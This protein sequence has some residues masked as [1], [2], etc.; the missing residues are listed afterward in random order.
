MSSSEEINNLFDDL[1]VGDNVRLREPFIVSNKVIIH[2]AI[3]SKINVARRSHTY[4]LT[5]EGGRIME[6]IKRS[7]LWK[8]TASDVDRLVARN[9][10]NGS[11]K[12]Y[13]ICESAQKQQQTC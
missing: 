4:D 1:V 5:L 8:L 9:V 3:V 7:Q 11:A 12:T 6:G 10:V 13:S 2:T